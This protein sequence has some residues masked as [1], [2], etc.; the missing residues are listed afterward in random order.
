[1]KYIL[2]CGGVYRFETPRWLIKVDGEP[3]IEHT[4]R[5]LRELGVE[6]ISISSNLDCFDYLDVPI[7][8][9]ENSY[10][11]GPEKEKKGYWTDAFVRLDEP[12]CYICGD[13]WFSK[14]AL[15]TIIDTQT[16]DIL[17]FGTQRPFH[18]A[19]KK[20]YEEPLAFKVVNQKRFQECIEEVN[21]LWD[22][23][24]TKRFPIAWELYRVIDGID[25]NKHLLGGRF[26]GI[27]D[28]ALDVDRPDDL[29]NFLSSIKNYKELQEKQ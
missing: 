19:Y 22:R 3:I 8:K 4:I 20:H 26:V 5:L 24:L 15:K 11:A 10:H 14:E 13:V 23:R 27:H 12:V 21:S 2:M 25:V 17:F 16:D 29:D 9:T 7:I 28:F 18:K 1:M 6:D